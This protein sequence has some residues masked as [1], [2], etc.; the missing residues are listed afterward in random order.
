[1]SILRSV[2]LAGLLGA[3]ACGGTDPASLDEAASVD[4]AGPTVCQPGVPDPH[5]CDP[6]DAHKTTICHIPPGNP[7][8][9][10]T[11]CVGSPAV[12]AHLAH[13]DHLGSCCDSTTPAPTPT[14]PAPTT[15]APPGGGTPAPGPT[16][17]PTTGPIG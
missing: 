6:A 8:N 2:C 4:N 16:P 12:P 10:H 7:A 11:L 3:A 17:D 9:A 15:P 5:V 13:G 14:T 1:M